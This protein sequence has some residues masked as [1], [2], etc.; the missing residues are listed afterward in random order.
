MKNFK[1]TLLHT[2]ELGAVFV[3]AYLLMRLF[4]LNSEDVQL[5]I[6]LLIG[7]TIKYARANEKIPLDDYVNK[8]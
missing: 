2:V 4:K 3:C 7:A 1:S 6:T 8:K 5:L